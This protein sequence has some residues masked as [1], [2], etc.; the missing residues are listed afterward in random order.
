M[1]IRNVGERY[2]WT[3]NTVDLGA[4]LGTRTN[5]YSYYISAFIPSGSDGK[6]HRVDCAVGGDPT[7]WWFVRSTGSTTYGNEPIRYTINTSLQR[8]TN[9]LLRYGIPT[10]S[11]TP[12]T[13]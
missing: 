13:Q 9:Y 10:G 4:G 2:G 1:E 7:V 5:T 8:V 3:I 12:L 11:N 6:P